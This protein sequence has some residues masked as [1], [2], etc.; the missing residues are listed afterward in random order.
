ML[1]TQPFPINFAQTLLLQW[2]CCCLFIYRRICRILQLCMGFPPPTTCYCGMVIFLHFIVQVRCSKWFWRLLL[3]QWL[4][5]WCNYVCLHPW[6]LG[7][8]SCCDNEV[9]CSCQLILPPLPTSIVLGYT[10]HFCIQTISMA[11]LFPSS[12]FLS[13][14]HCWAI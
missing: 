5:S 2:G 4:Q 8:T 10:V 6:W 11:L 13:A 14:R 12:Q 9:R 3:L 7:T 1:Q